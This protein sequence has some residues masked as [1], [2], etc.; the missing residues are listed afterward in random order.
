MARCFLTLF[1]VLLGTG[2]TDIVQE[3]EPVVPPDPEPEV[4]YED[5]G[6]VTG[7]LG[8][9]DAGV[10][11][12]LDLGQLFCVDVGFVGGYAPENSL[13]VELEGSS[14]AW[15]DDAYDLPPPDSFDIPQQWIQVYEAVET[16]GSAVVVFARGADMEYEESF[17]LQLLVTEQ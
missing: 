12:E 1:L 2:C 11:W 6:T 9:G 17:R 3:S 7:C 5:V 10:T 15:V 16:G 8:M 4:V 13:E 14:V